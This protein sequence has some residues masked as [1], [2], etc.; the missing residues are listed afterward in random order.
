[1]EPRDFPTKEDVLV[2]NYSNQKKT[3]ELVRKLA[4]RK[5]PGRADFCIPLLVPQSIAFNV[6]ER[7]PPDLAKLGARPGYTVKV[8]EEGNL[9]PERCRRRKTKWL[10]GFWQPSNSCMIKGPPF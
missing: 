7:V 3:E 8:D 10:P 5:H 4:E 1:M 9:E 2:N 6:S